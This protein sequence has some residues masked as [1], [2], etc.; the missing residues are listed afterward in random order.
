MTEGINS[1]ASGVFSF[2]I[3]KME[4]PH[5]KKNV[6][7]LV[8]PVRTEGMGI[9]GDLTDLQCGAIRLGATV[10]TSV[11]IGTNLNADGPNNLVPRA[12]K[13]LSFSQLSPGII[14]Q[15]IFCA[16]A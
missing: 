14:L 11:L 1:N 15:M 4:G 13:N 16:S 6:I 3:F 9:A 5:V 7:V 10:N 2:L 12:N 8:I